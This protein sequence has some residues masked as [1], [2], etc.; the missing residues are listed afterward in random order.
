VQKSS[1]LIFF[2]NGYTYKCKPFQAYWTEKGNQFIEAALN[3]FGTDSSTYYV[4]GESYWFSGANFRSKKGVNFA[5]QILNEIKEKLDENGKLFFVTHSMGS[6]FAEGMISVFLEQNIQVEKV[7]HF[8]VADAKNIK[9][10]KISENI[11]R[12]QIGISDDF[13][14]RFIGN[15][16]SL[17]KYYKIPKV[18]IYGEILSDINRFHKNVSEKDRKKWNFHYDTKTFAYIWDYVQKLEEYHSFLS[19]NKI[20][21]K[22]IPEDKSL[23]FKT[24]FIENSVFIL[25]KKSFELGIH[26]IKKQKITDGK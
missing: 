12:I 8:S 14:A 17:F 15:P 23:K 26:V 10:T 2:V 19:E 7:I 3:Y 9:L 20:N 21:S 6:A 25:E 16:M 24:L 18:K 4:N 5:K 22:S 1:K 13:T 11:K